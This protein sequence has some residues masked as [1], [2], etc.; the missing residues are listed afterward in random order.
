MDLRLRRPF[1]RPLDRVSDGRGWFYLQA[2]ISACSL[3]VLSRR[4][5]RGE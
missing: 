1:L 2:G 4:P 5:V 3:A